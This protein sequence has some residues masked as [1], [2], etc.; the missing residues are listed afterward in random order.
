MN[1]LEFAFRTGKIS[2]DYEK[3]VRCTTHI[4]IESCKKYGTTLYKLEKGNPV[5]IYSLDE[6]QRRCIEDLSCELHCQSQGNK[7]LIMHLDMFGLDEYR[8][9]VGLG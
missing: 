7:G 3:C 4:C 5:L 9:K 6:T 2:I 1:G 8:K